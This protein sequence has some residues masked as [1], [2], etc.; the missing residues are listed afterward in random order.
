M[1]IL[2]GTVEESVR[3]A[4]VEQ[5]LHKGVLGQELDAQ[6]SHHE[7]AEKVPV[8]HDKAAA[9]YVSPSLI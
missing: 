3:R 8:V 5:V 1:D 9:E 7:D 4:D 2:F 6:I